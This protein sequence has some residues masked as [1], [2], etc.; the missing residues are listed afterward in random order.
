MKDFRR[1]N[2]PHLYFDEGIYF[3]TYRLANSYPYSRIAKKQ[4]LNK[5][6]K[7]SNGFKKHFIR[8]DLQ[9]D[10]NNTYVNYLLVPEIA[11]ICKYTIHYYNNIQYKLICYCIMPNHIHLV[12]ELLSGNKGISKIMQSIKRISA[13]KSNIILNKKGK[14]WQDESYDRWVRDDIELY[15]IIRYV[16]Q[17]PVS[18]RLVNNWYE[19]EH[20]FCNKD[21]LVL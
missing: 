13:R 5:E 19:W 9:L 4:R 11:N 6:V 15:F 7:S 1:R 21:F 12:F 18:A 17:N 16:L 10:R 2:L 14:F 20:C 8:Y 3:I